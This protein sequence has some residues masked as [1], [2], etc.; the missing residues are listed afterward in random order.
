MNYSKSKKISDEFK[1]RFAIINFY[2]DLL[3]KGII[4][5]NGAA[6]NRMKQ[7]TIRVHDEV[8]KESLT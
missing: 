2:R 8:T 4:K 6:H 3:K 5:I 7:L 1:G